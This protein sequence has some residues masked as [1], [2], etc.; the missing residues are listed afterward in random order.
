VGAQTVGEAI[1]GDCVANHTGSF[2]RRKYL[3]GP[4]LF[5][6]GG[7]GLRMPQEGLLG[8][9]SPVFDQFPHCSRETAGFFVLDGY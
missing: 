8:G 2:V 6:A 1:R 5:S 4:E 3:V 9:C 7:V